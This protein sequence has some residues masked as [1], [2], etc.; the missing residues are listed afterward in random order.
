[1]AAWCTSICYLQKTQKPKPRVGKVPAPLSWSSLPPTDCFLTEY[2]G[3][4]QVQLET[5]KPTRPGS[6]EGQGGWRAAGGL[7]GLWFGCQP[8]RGREGKAEGIL[9]REERR[10]VALLGLKGD[11]ERTEESSCW[12]T[13]RLQ[14]CNVETHPSPLPTSICAVSVCRFSRGS[15]RWVTF[16]PHS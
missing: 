15:I 9:V 4:Q 1:M 12:L 16:S 7:R 3:W 10:S 6:G 11:K 2:L 13:G 8:G 5:G 14:C